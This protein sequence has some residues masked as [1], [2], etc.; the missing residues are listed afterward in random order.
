L[1]IGPFRRGEPIEIYPPSRPG[2]VWVGPSPIIIIAE[3]GEIDYEDY[4]EYRP[5][6][7]D[8]IVVEAVKENGD[9]LQTYALTTTT[10][11][12][13]TV[14]APVLAGWKLATGQSGT[15]TG[16]AGM[17]P[18]NIITFVYAPDVFTIEVT[19]EDAIGT[20]LTAPGYAMSY[21]VAR[22]LNL[23]VYA[24]HIPGYVITGIQNKAFNNVDASDSVTF[25]YETIESLFVTVTV[26]GAVV[27]GGNEL[28]SYTQLRQK[29]SGTYTITAL[30]V[31]GYAIAG[32][33]V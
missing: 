5:I 3:E 33:Y 1:R 23:T 29:G 22:G 26:R 30:N 18:D 10:G 12:T 4:G 16:T 6:T 13:M 9:L 8:Q 21:T 7:T 14:N 17:S 15:G 28:Y 24:P 27:P 11:N 19:L 31:T 20:A 32:P 25:V 2:H